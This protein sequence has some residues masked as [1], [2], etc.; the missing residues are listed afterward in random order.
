VDL[1]GEVDYLAAALSLAEVEDYQE[2]VD[3]PVAV[4]CLGEVE[5]D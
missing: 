1:L 5:V 3:Y 2:E 4:D